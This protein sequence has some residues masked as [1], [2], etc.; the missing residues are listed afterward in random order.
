MVMKNEN[1]L[2]WY[3]FSYDDPKNPIIISQRSYKKL[4]TFLYPWL[5]EKIDC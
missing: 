1:N 4:Y 5:K 3:F 2:I